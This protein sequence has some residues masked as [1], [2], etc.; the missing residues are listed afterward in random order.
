MRESADRSTPNRRNRQPLVGS[1]SQHDPSRDPHVVLRRI[2][3]SRLHVIS[4]DSQRNGTD[5]FVVDSAAQCGGKRRIL[6][7]IE[8]VWEIRSLVRLC[9]RRAK[10]G[11][12]EW[13]EPSHRH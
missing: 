7:L 10:Q 11:L 8:I 13:P 3:E 1:K 6:G 5:K 2:K 9:M 4:L 12:G